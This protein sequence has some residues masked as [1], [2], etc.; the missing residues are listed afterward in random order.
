MNSKIKAFFAVL[1]LYILKPCLCTCILLVSLI[2][3]P[4]MLLRGFLMLCNL[5]FP[6]HGYEVASLVIMVVF[7]LSALIVCVGAFIGYIKDTVIPKYKYTVAYFKY[8][9]GEKKK[10]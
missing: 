9:E 1:W 8:K 4:W 10:K 7:L 2:A 5:W 3:I 6:T